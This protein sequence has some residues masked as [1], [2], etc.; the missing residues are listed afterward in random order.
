MARVQNHFG[1]LKANV[2]HSPHLKC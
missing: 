2:F 1:L